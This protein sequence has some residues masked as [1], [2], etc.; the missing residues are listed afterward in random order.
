MF[1][2][3]T[4]EGDAQVLLYPNKQSCGTGLAKVVAEAS[5]RAI[6][7]RGCFTVALSGKPADHHPPSASPQHWVPSM[8]GARSCC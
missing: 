8:G 2:Y 1:N 5:A 3:P 7:E 4:A 6:Q